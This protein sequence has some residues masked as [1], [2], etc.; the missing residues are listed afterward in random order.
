MRTWLNRWQ[1]WHKFALLG[2]LGLLLV[3]PPLALY[4]G[5]SHT[6]MAALQLERQGIVPVRAVLSAVA[7]LQ[8][9]RA[10]LVRQQSDT[11][12]P[13]NTLRTSPSDIENALA[14]VQARLPPHQSAILVHL[15]I[16]TQDAWT[17][18]RS[19]LQQ[20]PAPHAT[21]FTQ[22]TAT[23][24]LLLKIKDQLVD[25]YGFSLDPQPKT[26]LLGRAALVESLSLLE[27]LAQVHDTCIRLLAQQNLSPAEAALLGTLL[28]KITDDFDRLQN[29]TD[30]ATRDD[31]VL[32]AALAQPLLLNRSRWLHTLPALLR[33]LQAP[34]VH[35]LA[36][37]SDLAGLD[38][39]MEAQTNITEDALLALQTSLDDRLDDLNATRLSLSGGMLALALFLVGLASLVARSITRPL[40]QAVDIARQ[41]ADGTLPDNTEVG[42]PGNE[43]G[44]LL[45]SLQ[46]MHRSLQRTQAERLASQQQVATA[47]REQQVIF[48]AV[49]LGIIFAVNHTIQRSNPAMERMFGYAPGELVGRGTKELFLSTT[50]LAAMGHRIN[51][52]MQE[53]GFFSSDVELRQQDGSPLWVHTYG[54][55]IDAHNLHQG[56]VWVFDDISDQRAAAEELRQAKDAAEQASQAKSNFLANMSHEIR[57]PMNAI[58]GMSHLALK[59]DLDPRQ[60]D[61]V[62]KIRQSG[63]HLLGILNDILDFSK[64][65]A[66]KLEIEHAAFDLEQVLANVV[67]VVADKTQAKNLELVCDLPADIPLQLVGDPLR[68]GQ[69]LINYVTNAIK[70]TAQGEIHISIRLQ[71]QAEG[72]ILLRFAVRDTGIGLSQEQI[73][74]L[75]QS[76]SQADSSTTRQY[77]G[78]GLGLAICKNLAALMG[79]DVGVDSTPGVGST[80]WFTARLGLGERRVRAPLPGSATLR[81]RRVLV[82]DDND[83][84]ATVLADMLQHMGF[85]VDAVSSGALAIAAVRRQAASATPY[86]V[87]M[88]DWQMPGMDGLQAIQQLRALALQPPPHTILVTAYGREEVIQNARSAQVPDILLKPVGA[89]LLLD[90]MVNIL[91][92]ARTQDRRDRPPGVSAAM[93]ALA[94]LRGA[95]ILLVEDNELNQQVAFELLQDAGF[96]VDIADNGLIAVAMVG[97]TDY[98][99][100]LMDMQMPVMDGVAATQEIRT[101]G[102]YPNLPI[103]AMTANAMQSDRDRCLAAGMD[104]F[105]AK[106]IEPD[107][108]WRA[109]AQWIR[110]RA[111]LGS[112]PPPSAPHAPTEPVD[113]PQGIPGLDTTLG[114]KRVMGKQS[115]YLSMLRKFAT[116]QAHATAHIAQA[117]QDGDQASAERIAHTLKGVA[118]NIGASALQHAAGLLETA[119]HAQQASDALL[120]PVHSQLAALVA[121]LHNAL[122]APA[123]LA[124]AD[125]AQ[126]IPVLAQLR[127]LLAEDDSDAAELFQQH[128]GLLQS[129]LGST[130]AAVASAMADYNFEAALQALNTARPG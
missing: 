28:D 95:H 26:Y 31:P 25:D 34:S 104:S 127:S 118:G 98:D 32:R 51:P 9:N 87:V 23:V 52:A 78:T 14:E 128:S 22:H 35:G 86:E 24:Q 111:G 56:V 80:F 69:I 96:R 45:L 84:A 100:V 16:Q 60:R 44:R 106:P 11:A 38:A 71:T 8:K 6:T 117:L 33:Q 29:T 68:L 107:D 46:D 82:V 17:A 49:S 119:L 41:V 116:G 7:L 65:E 123:A 76:F 75:F 36:Q 3:A 70:F 39:T 74:R 43:T 37:D 55:A 54:R 93:A 58:I 19:A 126:L 30:K 21:I 61:Y 5:G 103:V 125:L 1:L 57:T 59:T 89:S 92:H 115:L 10:Q 47:L 12:Q 85:V 102:N 4:W 109:L 53:S 20:T 42:H 130:H 97:Q 120:A 113:I 90:T 50:D 40:L 110:P 27:S 48:E 2:L 79:G 88:M 81:G 91:G 63:Q 15:W 105:V 99:L 62:G 121:A 124:E 108:L 64:V 72:N 94:P 112:P 114:L 13:F 67:N 129:A 18:L 77:G 66:G 83:S 101:T 73:G 122:P